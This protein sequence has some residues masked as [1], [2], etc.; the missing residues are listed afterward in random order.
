MG[1]SPSSPVISL[2]SSSSFSMDELPPRTNTLIYWSRSKRECLR[3]QEKN[4]VL[5]P[6]LIYSESETCQV[7][8]ETGAGWFLQ[9]SSPCTHFVHFDICIQ[10]SCPV[11]KCLPRDPELVQE[12][13]R[14]RPNKYDAASVTVA[15]LMNWN[16]RFEAPLISLS[17]YF[18]SAG[19]SLFISSSFHKKTFALHV[20]DTLFPC[21]ND[22]LDNYLKHELGL[23]CE[24]RHNIK[25]GYDP[26]C[27]Y[28]DLTKTNWDKYRCE[29]E[30]NVFGAEYA[31]R[32]QMQHLNYDEKLNNLDMVEDDRQQ[33]RQYFNLHFYGPRLEQTRRV[34]IC[35]AQDYGVLINRLVGLGSL[36]HFPSIAVVVMFDTT[37][38][39]WKAL[40]RRPPPLIIPTG[41]STIRIP[42]PPPPPRSKKPQQPSH[43]EHSAQDGDENMKTGINN[44]SGGGST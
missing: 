30:A 16:L 20:T 18:L 42:P 37:F 40:I 13:L 33:M 29:Q 28:S 21:C 31:Q 25:G 27:A 26:H 10:Q 43:E 44:I 38:W 6:D 2:P 9:F 24:L 15:K 39:Y 35:F 23:N 5:V 36:Q 22:S 1:T 14:E 7:C 34:Y 41:K 12:I 11:C 8:N 4:A 17:A 3:Y 19:G 32:L